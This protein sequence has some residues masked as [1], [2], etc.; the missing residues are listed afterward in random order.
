MKLPKD[1]KNQFFNIRKFTKS[2]GVK[3]VY[4]LDSKTV[5][6]DHFILASDS[7]F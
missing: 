4:F 6:I 7:W 5:K 3:I 2:F 1:K